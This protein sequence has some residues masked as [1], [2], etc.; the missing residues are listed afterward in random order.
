M[1]FE[2]TFQFSTVK[3]TTSDENGKDYTQTLMYYDSNGT[4]NG[5]VGADNDDQDT[6]GKLSVYNVTTYDGLVI[7]KYQFPTD[8]SKDI[9]TTIEYYF[10]DVNN[11]YLSSY[12]VTQSAS[13]NEAGVRTTNNSA[14]IKMRFDGVKNPGRWGHCD[15]DS[16]P[17][18]PRAQ[19]RFN[20][21]PSLVR[22]VTA[23]IKLHGSQPQRLYASS[24]DTDNLD[25]DHNTQDDGEFVQAINNIDLLTVPDKYTVKP[26]DTF[27][28]I[29]QNQYGDA[30]FGQIIAI[31]NNYPSVND[32][33][34]ACSV[35]TLPQYIPMSNTSNNNVPYNTF[36]NAIYGN[37]Y[38]P[39]I[40]AQPPPPKNDCTQTLILVA[41]AVVAIA[42]ATTVVGGPA[43]GA[44]ATGAAGALGGTATAAGAAAAVSTTVVI[45]QSLQ[46]AVLAG[47]LDASLQGAAFGVGALQHFSLDSVI[48]TAVTGG[49]FY[50]VNAEWGHSAFYVQ[51]LAQTTASGAAD[52][53][54]QLIEMSVGTRKRLDINQ[55][56][57]SMATTAV[58]VVMTAGMNPSLKALGISNQ[59]ATNLVEDFVN[60]YTNAFL[61][62]AIMGGKVDLNN[63]L[64]QALGSF[65]GQEIST[66]LPKTATVSD[67]AIHDYFAKRGDAIQLSYNDLVNDLGIHDLNGMDYANSLTM[68]DIQSV[69]TAQ[70]PKS[71]GQKP[72][73]SIAQPNS[74][75][76]NLKQVQ[77]ALDQML[78]ATESGYNPNKG[79]LLSSWGSSRILYYC[80]FKFY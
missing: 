65:I 55:T 73:P 13:Q 12:T 72:D 57:N 48:E 79:F 43:G 21:P 46:V 70:A 35:L 54:S 66:L 69:G 59:A 44:M 14:A 5:K 32:Q 19:S 24:S 80:H 9:D 39:L 7:E 75:N 67:A 38:P 63:A 49:M 76:A 58:N 42:A 18:T 52:L 51:L 2:D 16:Q 56:L 3:G 64:G 28:S 71:A 62:S 23:K 74:Y 37:L 1:L 25:D 17:R 15:L 26:G 6:D 4:L 30:S 77:Q 53:S 27:T 50:G 47:A 36:Q 22:P 8:P 11:N 40:F 68:D 20:T 45:T 61:G 60:A 33:P 29:A 10:Y 78:V 31:K 41:C 34:S